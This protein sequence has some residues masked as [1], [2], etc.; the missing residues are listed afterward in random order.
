MFGKHLLP[1]G[2][3]ISKG[4]SCRRSSTIH[5]S[6]KAE[7]STQ[8]AMAK[9]RQR[10]EC[11]QEGQGG[12]EGCLQSSPT[13]KTSKG[14]KHA[15]EMTS[16]GA[17]LID[18]GG[19]STRPGSKTVNPKNEWN[20]I[21]RILRPICK[22]I[23]VSLDT[24]KSEIMEQGIKLGVEIINDVSGLNYDKKTLDILK[25]YQIPFV[26][27][28]SKGTPENMQIKPTYNN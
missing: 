19:E 21:Y 20:R 10:Q 26:I 22:K 3:N 11:R 4:T 17:N 7:P 24:R 5:R 6:R 13:R 28:H 14:I 8:A 25:K 1:A 23:S 9:F 18:I 12:R 16:A 2:S 15:L 27:Q